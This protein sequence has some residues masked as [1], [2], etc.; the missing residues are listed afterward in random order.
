MLGIQAKES[1]L[2]AKCGKVEKNMDCSTKN[3]HR[4]IREATKKGRASHVH[5]IIKEKKGTF[6]FE[7]KNKPLHLKKCVT[8]LHSDDPG[9]TETIAFGEN[10]LVHQFCVKNLT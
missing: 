3:C 8:S 2:D 9:D 4:P 6:L 5:S 1:F 7:S 10:I